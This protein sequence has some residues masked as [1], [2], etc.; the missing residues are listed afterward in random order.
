MLVAV[1]LR[2]CTSL[3]STSTRPSYKVPTEAVAYPGSTK[4]TS[5]CQTPSSLQSAAHPSNPL[6]CETVL[7]MHLAAAAVSLGDCV[8]DPVVHRGDSGGVDNGTLNDSVD[9]LGDASVQFLQ[10]STRRG[11]PR[12]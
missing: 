11:I 10:R 3:M 1:V 8:D 12:H 5:G 7:Y 6:I 2:G 9:L 4:A